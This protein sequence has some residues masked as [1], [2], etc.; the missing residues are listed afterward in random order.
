M[1]KACFLS[2]GCWVLL[3]LSAEA[4]QVSVETGT[5][6]TRFGGVAGFA[7]LVSAPQATQTNGAVASTNGSILKLVFD[8]QTVIDPATLIARPF[9]V[10]LSLPV[11]CNGAHN[12][13]V[14]SSRGGMQLQIPVAQAVGLSSR[15][16]L[17]VAA[18]WLGDTG[19]FTTSGTPTATSI[20]Q[21]NAGSG[22]IQ[23]TVSG[24]NGNNP[25]VAGR[26]SDEIV[27]DLTALQ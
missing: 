15:I 2:L 22:L 21:K 14:R 17:S 12:V 6:T 27:I 23:V 11:I 13:S 16:D 7:C 25:L 1:N 5:A 26:Y 3:P 20:P 24:I 9:T 4:Q 10:S 8:S 18:L 19:L